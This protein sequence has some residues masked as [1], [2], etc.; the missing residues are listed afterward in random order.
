[1]R[2]NAVFATKQLG[3]VTELEQFQPPLPN[4]KLGQVTRPDARLITERADHQRGTAVGS[5]KG[6]QKRLP[7]DNQHRKGRINRSADNMPVAVNLRTEELSTSSA[8]RPPTPVDVTE[9]QLAATSAGTVE[10]PLRSGRV[11]R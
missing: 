2:L 8:V 1:S 5:T 6:S 10:H 7:V 4:N 9:L 3:G 11:V